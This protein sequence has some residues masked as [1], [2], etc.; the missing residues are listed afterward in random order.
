MFIVYCLPALDY[1]QGADD[2]V[3][4]VVCADVSGSSSNT[5]VRL[6][7]DTG[8]PPTGVSACGVTLCCGVTHVCTRRICSRSVRWG[9]LFWLSLF[10]CAFLGRTFS[11]WVCY[12]TSWVIIFGE[13]RGNFGN[14]FPGAYGWHMCWPSFTYFDQLLLFTVRNDYTH[15]HRDLTQSSGWLIVDFCK[16][17]L[18]FFFCPHTFL[19]FCSFTRRDF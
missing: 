13:T 8:L 4:R 12:R 6:K 5:P 14:S 7:L 15:P 3:R 1:W 16:L 17:K 2:G 11:S 19:E 9:L 18:F 10:L